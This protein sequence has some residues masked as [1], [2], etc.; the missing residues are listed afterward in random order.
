MSG[1]RSSETRPVTLPV[2]CG[3]LLFNA[4]GELLLCHVTNTRQWDIPKGM[5][6]AGESPL[7]AAMRELREETG[8]VF[9]AACFRDL[10][11]QEYRPDKHLHLF[12]IAGPAPFEQL[13]H[14]VCESYFPHPRTG[15]PTPEADRFRWAARCEII[16][17]CWPRMAKRLLA[18]DWP[19]A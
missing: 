8:L 2:S 19:G 10:G 4:A 13:D 17:L 12:C 3:T 5:Q 11:C 6:D 1:A 15:L 9:D 18:A 16:R 14:L 7:Q